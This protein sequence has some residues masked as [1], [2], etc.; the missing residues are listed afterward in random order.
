MPLYPYLSPTR[1][2]PKP[3]RCLPSGGATAPAVVACRRGAVVSSDRTL[4][5]TLGAIVQD[6]IYVDQEIHSLIVRS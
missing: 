5:L 1:K 3:P 6:H 2:W 4:W